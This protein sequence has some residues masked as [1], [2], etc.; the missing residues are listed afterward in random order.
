MAKFKV[1]E[2]SQP[3]EV[4]DPATQAKESLAFLEANYKGN[5]KYEAKKAFLEAKL[6]GLTKKASK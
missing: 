3:P 4:K 6:A 5:P 1:G 2:L